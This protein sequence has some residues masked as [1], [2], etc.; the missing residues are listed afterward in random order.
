MQV[1]T[2]FGRAFAGTTCATSDAGMVT[3]L[4]LQLLYDPHIRSPQTELLYALSTQREYLAL[5][6]DFA[7]HPGLTCHILPLLRSV[8][9]SQG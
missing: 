7:L 8:S 9:D 6:C 5:L 3:S 2:R 4:S 1:Q